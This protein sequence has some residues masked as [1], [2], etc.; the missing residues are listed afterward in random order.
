MCG[1]GGRGGAVNDEKA[2]HSFSKGASCCNGLPN[3]SFT[4]AGEYQ[5][6][7]TCQAVVGVMERGLRAACH[8]ESRSAAHSGISALRDIAA[9]FT[10]I[11]PVTSSREMQ[12]VPAPVQ[13]PP[14]GCVIVCEGYAWSR[15]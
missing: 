10:A 11:P 9:L 3:Y 4:V 8:L 6:S 13:P 12:V 15:A 5:I 1:G 14:W 2:G 7:R